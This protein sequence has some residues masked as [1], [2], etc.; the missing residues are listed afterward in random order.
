MKKYE[1]S[2]SKPGLKQRASQTKLTKTS[3]Q[4][5]QKLNIAKNYLSEQNNRF[6]CPVLKERIRTNPRNR[7]TDGYRSHENSYDEEI[8]EPAKEITISKGVFFGSSYLVQRTSLVHK[9][10]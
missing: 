7:K 2:A 3:Y 8:A 5:H 4:A 6:K 9:I 10:S 1:S